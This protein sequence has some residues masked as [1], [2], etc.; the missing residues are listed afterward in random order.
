LLEMQEEPAGRAWPVMGEQTGMG[1]T[2]A[3][4]CLFVPVSGLSIRYSSASR[5]AISAWGFVDL[6]AVACIMH[7]ISCSFRSAAAG[8][9]P[10]QLRSDS[11]LPTE[12][13]QPVEVMAGYSSTAWLAWALEAIMG[14][15]T[16]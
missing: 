3:P 10:S 7:S 11:R 15:G 9:W 16:W 12:A 4:D 13:S 1:V 14:F 8:K 5:Q 6:Y 2:C